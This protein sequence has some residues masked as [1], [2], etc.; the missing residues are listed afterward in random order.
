MDLDDIHLIWYD[1][2]TGKYYV[3]EPFHNVRKALRVIAAKQRDTLQNDEQI[4]DE[5]DEKLRM[6]QE[7]QHGSN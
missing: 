4:H 1:E 7:M 5:V 2:R 6:I 3:F